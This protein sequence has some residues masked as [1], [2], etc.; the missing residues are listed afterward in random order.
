MRKRDRC[1]KLACLPF[2]TN[3]LLILKEKIIDK[4]L[5]YSLGPIDSYLQSI[6]LFF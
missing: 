4:M 2:Y 6:F 3:Y 1:P 5:G